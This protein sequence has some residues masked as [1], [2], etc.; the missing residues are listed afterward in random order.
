VAIKY[1][2]VVYIPHVDLKLFICTKG[3]AM[4]FMI[5]HI[6]LEWEVCI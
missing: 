2:R 3:G 1:T 6:S 5:N 4:D